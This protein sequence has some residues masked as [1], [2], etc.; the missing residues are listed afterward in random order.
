MPSNAFKR[1]ISFLK[2]SASELSK[3]RSDSD[4]A[5]RIRIGWKL[6]E[7]QQIDPISREP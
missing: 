7:G 3:Q 5:M 4:I 1:S 6:R 2:L